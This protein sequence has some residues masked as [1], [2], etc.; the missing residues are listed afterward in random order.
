MMK[1]LKLLTKHLSFTTKLLLI[2]FGFVALGLLVFL[3]SPLLLIWIPWSIAWRVGLTGLVS[4]IV[5][6]IAWWIIFNMLQA[7]LK[8]IKNAKDNQNF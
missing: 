4:S 6:F 3:S 8:Q 1:D 2:L 5:L 7:T